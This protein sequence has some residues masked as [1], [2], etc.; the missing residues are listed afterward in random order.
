MFPRPRSALASLLALA[1]LTPCAFAQG[2]APTRPAAAPGRLA[3]T[4]T[5]AAK[6]DY[7]AAKILYA[8]GDYAGSA[9][10]FH[11][12]YT[13][14][15]DARLLWNE[16][17]AEKNQRHY[18]RVE[19]LIREYLA[20]GGATSEADRADAQGLIDTVRAFIGD[21]RVTCKEAGASVFIDNAEVGTTPLESALRVDMGSRRVRVVKAG[22]KEFTRNIEVVGGGQLS[23]D[24]ELT[25]E[26]HEGTLRVVGGVGTTILIDGKMVGMGQWQG[27]LPSGLHMVEV[28]ADK[29]LPYRS[30]S[31]VQDGELTT[32]QVSLQNE[33]AA[34]PA[35]ASK[36]NYTWLWVAGG[37]VLATGLGVGA[38]FAFRPENQ[39][40]PAPIEGSIGGVQL[41]LLRR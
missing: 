21:V 28:S 30:D 1:L 3:D 14:S 5:G 24:A 16:A 22:F 9:L 19:A 38:Y 31:L 23:V 26:V 15:K 25:A 34:A 12:A 4:L 37:A 2:G 35:A 17:A 7:E 27:T 18:A 6:D 39:G 13:L 36:S 20:K 41:G 8:D 33:P 32:V 10:K 40:P 11:Q 29:K